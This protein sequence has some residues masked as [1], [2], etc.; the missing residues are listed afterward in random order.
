MP[1]GCHPAAGT[2]QTTVGPRRMGAFLVKRL[3]FSI[4]T[5]FTVLTLVFVVI[6]IVPGDPAQ[7]ILG[8]QADATA[9]AAL[10]ARLG[11]D[12]PL[13]EQYVSF[14]SGA[15]R[16]DWGVSLVTGR[17]V[18]QEIVAVL[19]WT[20]ELTAVSMVLGCLIGIPLGVWAA[21][22]RNRMPD[23]LTRMVSLVGLS[24]PPF[25]SAIL[26]LIGFSLALRWFPV[27]SGNRSTWWAWFQSIAL[28]SLNLGLI[29]AAYITRVT[30]SAMLEVM[31]EDYVRTAR[32]KGVP[33]RVIVWRHAL[34]N[35]LIPVVTVVGLYLGIL[36][37]NSVLTEIV[38]NRPGLGKLIIGALSQRDYMML[39]GMMVIYTLIVVFV[40]VLTD[41]T[42]A[43]IDPRVKLS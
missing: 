12:R 16:G 10:R 19:P 31:Q 4:V 41:I 22:N 21:I 28:P 3:L 17:P 20:L 1:A 5:L 38:F 32:A 43:V 8:D 39:Q 24:F 13:F 26:L 2:A 15:L 30:R 23:Y 40:N 29:M 18:I 9:I 6:R 14:L 37:G 25:V 7:V 33:W 11:I 42:Y 34:R 36:I 35:A 27:I